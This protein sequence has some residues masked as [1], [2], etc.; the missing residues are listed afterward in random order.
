MHPRIPH[1]KHP[2]ILTYKHTHTHR[3]LPHRK[4]ILPHM[5][6]NTCTHSTTNA[7]FVVHIIRQARNYLHIYKWKLC[8]TTKIYHLSFAHNLLIIIQ[9]NYYC[10]IVCWQNLICV[11]TIYSV[12]VIRFPNIYHNNIRYYYIRYRHHISHYIVRGKRTTRIWSYLCIRI[13]IPIAGT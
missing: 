6:S 13:K 3:I 12:V 11:Y 1:T 9:S 8:N 10:T 4:W 5:F 2:H 7:S